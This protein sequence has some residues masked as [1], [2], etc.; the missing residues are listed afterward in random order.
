MSMRI[1]FREQP[2]TLLLAT[3]QH[4][5]TFQCVDDNSSAGST[6]VDRSGLHPD[7]YGMTSTTPSENLADRANGNGSHD[8][9]GG[10]SGSTRVL[11]DFT[12]RDSIDF[13]RYRLLS[14]MPCYGCLGLICVERNVFLAVIT[15]ATRVAE[16]V[17]QL[18]TVHRINKVEFYCVSK[19]TW[20]FVVLDPAGNPLDTSNYITG[21]NYDFAMSQNGTTPTAT[22][23]EHPCVSIRKLLMDGSFYYS[24]D[25]DLTN[26]MQSRS[27][28]PSF[29]IDGF[30]EAFMWN[31][32]MISELVK[33]RSHLQTEEKLALDN[34]RFLT[35]VIRGFAETVPTHIM[36]EETTTTDQGYTDTRAV[37]KSATLTVISRQGCRRAG[38][39]YNAR[40][41]DD[42][43]N[44]ANFVET[45]TIF[46]VDG[47]F[48]SY[49]QIRGSVPI[50]W[51]QDVQL[52][53]AKVNITRAFEAT[54]PAFM[55]HFDPLVAKYGPVHIVNLLS[56]KPGEAELTHRY[57]KHIEAAIHGPL[58]GQLRETRFDFHVETARAGYAAAENI[59]VPLQ[60]DVDEFKFFLYDSSVKQVLYEQ[61]G[62]F[63]TNCLDCLDRTNLIQQII[64][65]WALQNFLESGFR[66]DNDLWMRHSVLWADNGDQLSKMYA[67]T[68]ALKTSFTRSGKMSIAGAIADATKSVSRMYINN[69][70]DKGRQNTIDMLLGRLEGQMR[71]V[72]HDPINDYVMAELNRRKHEF[73]STRE[74]S[75]FVGTFNLN[76]FL[77]DRDLSPWLFPEDSGIEQPDLVIVAFQEIVELTASQ[78][79]NADPAKREYW[80]RRVSKCLEERGNYVLLRSAQLVGT[81]LLMYVK[82]TEVRHVKN[83]NGAMQKTGLGGMAGNKGGIAFSCDYSAT[84]LC[85]ITSHLAAGLSNVEDRN[86]DYR[87]I[88]R[89]I[90]FPRGKKLG[91]HD[92][93]IWLG[94]F[95]YRIDL[96]I[97]E[98]KQLIETNELDALYKYDQLNKQMLDG[99]VFPFFSE[100]RI[101]FDPTYKFNNGTEVYDTEKLRIPAW[102]DRVLTR[103]QNIKQLSYNS[104][105]VLFSDHKPVYASFVVTVNTINA[106]LKEKLSQELYARQRGYVGQ[107]LDLDGEDGQRLPPPSTDK[108]KWWMDGGQSA[109]VNIAPPRPGMVL[110]PSRPANPFSGTRQPDFVS[111]ATAHMATSRKSST[112]FEGI[113]AAA[114]ASSL[115]RH[116]SDLS[117]STSHT[118]GRYPPPL[119]RK[120][121]SLSGASIHSM[122]TLPPSPETETP[123]ILPPRRTFSSSTT[124]SVN[125]Q[126]PVDSGAYIETPLQTFSGRAGRVDPSEPRSGVTMRS[127]DSSTSSTGS[128]SMQTVNPPRPADFPSVSLSKSGRLHG[129]AGQESPK[130]PSRPQSLSS[131]VLTPTTTSSSTGGGS[132]WTLVGNQQVASNAST[133]RP[134]STLQPTSATAT[135]VHHPIRTLHPTPGPHHQPSTTQQAP[136]AASTLPS[137]AARTA[138][139]LLDDDEDVDGSELN[140]HWK[141]LA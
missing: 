71:V 11:V 34:A 55:T 67:G 104:A 70:V 47:Y 59:K 35:S 97:D 7:R 73:T 113:A 39:R 48:F 101:G 92:T 32:F 58:M 4:A 10:S 133:H 124:S 109:K 106:P 41:V 116:P 123:P 65:K 84:S 129:A 115:A 9:I 112:S 86:H 5:L 132:Y 90:R 17:P 62:V 30:D 111:T 139:A 43:G 135:P 75:I 94:D 51:E 117:P 119:P 85:F 52:L 136:H 14:S 66:A 12:P 20:D 74:I 96:P 54:Q 134:M 16:P 122:H 100:A 77:Y 103:G 49:T 105:N 36:A 141:S 87:T 24:N 72:L 15:E 91:D 121:H 8:T 45:E 25:F 60:N 140:S 46:Q 89:G 64:S 68:G 33:Y 22:V 126:S 114:A 95:N 13:G 82:S 78:I 27:S 6:E 31:S 63:R 53:S 108:R 93:V 23:I 118:S 76:G 88:A 98:V 81:A 80:E 29:D 19:S 138:K 110:N 40:G 56:S 107:L 79:L 131:S 18:E 99:Q 1:Y 61:T 125:S 28:D 21:D 130:L 2:R 38:T 137:A 50:F 83:I 26:R 127:R 57:H 37:R 128:G 44:V 102:T 3:E 120:P 42:E 69:F